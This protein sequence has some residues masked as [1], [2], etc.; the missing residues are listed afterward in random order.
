MKKRFMAI[1]L[2]MAVGLLV[3]MIV[4]AHAQIAA[5]TANKTGSNDR[6][7]NLIMTSSSIEPLV[8]DSP[9]LTLQGMTAAEQETL[10]VVL[11]GQI[12]GTTSAV[13]IQ[14]QY[15][16]IG[17]GQRL[18][19]QDISNPAAPVFVGQTDPLPGNVKGVAVAGSYVYVAAFINGLRVIDASNPAAP[20]EVGFL[21]TTGNPQNVA[22]AENYVYLV[23]LF[24]GLHIIDVSVPTA[25][26]EVGFFDTPG[27][28]QD[29]AIAG[30]TAYVADGSGGL[31]LIDVSNPA[32]P[33]EV[34]FYDTPQEAR[35]V[36]VAG[37]YAYVADG[38]SG[39]RIIDA[40]VP[41][42]AFEAGF[43]DT[44]EEALDVAVADSYAYVADSFSGLRVIAVS[45]PAAAFEMGYYDTP[46]EARVVAA[47]GLQAYVADSDSLQ[48]LR[49]VPPVPVPNVWTHGGPYGGVID[50]L[51]LHPLTPTVLYATAAGSGIFATVDSAGQ[52]YPS[53]ITPGPERPSVDAV[54]PQ[55]LYSG[56]ANRC[57]RSRD[58]GNT[59]DEG[60][61]PSSAPTWQYPF[62]FRPATHP[63]I[64][65][66]V[67]LG[68]SV[69]D[70]PATAGHL[71]R[72]SDGGDSWLDLTPNLPQ[73]DTN[74]TAITFDPL[75]ANHIFVGTRDGYIYLSTNG[76]SSWTQAAR[77]DAHIERLVVN[78]FGVH[79]VWAVTNGTDWG[80]SYLWRSTDSALTQWEQNFQANNITFHP[81]ISGTIWAASGGG[82]V[83]VDGG[84]NWGPVAVGL[85]DVLDFAIDPQNPDTV[86]VGTMRGVHKS[87]DNG[88]TWAEAVTGLSGVLPNL[89]LAALPINPDEVYAASNGRVFRSLTGGQV[90]DELAAPQIWEARPHMRLLAVDPAVPTRIYLGDSHAFAVHHSDDKG[91][92]WLTA[93]LPLPP[94]ATDGGI[95]CVMPH[96]TIPGRILA[97]AGLYGIPGQYPGALYLS[98]N[99]GESWSRINT[100]AI[101]GVATV[102]FDPASP[103][104]GFA[105]TEGGGLLKSTDGGITWQPL[106]TWTSGDNVLAVAVHPTNHKVFASTMSEGQGIFVSANGGLSWNKLAEQPTTGPVWELLFTQ[107]ALPVL[108]AGGMESG[109][110]FSTDEG[111][112]WTSTPGLPAMANV[113]SLASVVVGQQEVLYV[114]TSGGAVTTEGISRDTAA[115]NM[116]GSGVYRQMWITSHRIYLPVVIRP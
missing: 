105:G 112:S 38:S 34:G 31:R 35:G 36:A 68:L 85:T 108:Y 100:G 93:A 98:E 76:G 86:Y 50:N 94:G 63:T 83:S 41:A 53:L 111:L 24:N 28:P 109:L 2:S 61:T 42:T 26:V 27:E 81:T 12:T 57:L 69:P 16:Y 39:L 110:S 21:M 65:G 51:V 18:T 101:S 66:R 73:V 96:P 116:L 43:Y 80:T 44:P 55:W 17:S 56:S 9:P 10:N 104:I 59:W 74:I 45:N 103:Q 79:E 6:F 114:G 60:C 4:A 102:V 46:G 7:E 82:Y 22:V 14:G 64:G 84:Q 32:V 23:D 91:Q 99:Y 3:T 40:S 70:G 20:V 115:T 113:P 15:A 88:Q 95:W 107:G 67:Y 33:S 87:L 29:V 49:F 13:A 77:P 78:P 92:S 106:T 72:S 52:W 5:A 1:G 11:D 47:A 25:P 90:W 8:Q 62:R 54:N 19:I 58:G 30:S 97:G 37:S 75:D 89:G 71:Y 48:I